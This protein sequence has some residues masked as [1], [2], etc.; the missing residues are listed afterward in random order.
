MKVLLVVLWATYPENQVALT[1]SIK[2]A[3][4]GKE[5]KKLLEN[6]KSEG[7]KVRIRP[8][9]LEIAVGLIEAEISDF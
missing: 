9:P 5:S 2:V 7:F 3:L 4:I 6:A 1:K 8:I